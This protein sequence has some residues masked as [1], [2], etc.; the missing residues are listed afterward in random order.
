MKIYCFDPETGIYLGED[1]ADEGIRR[2]EYIIP[3]DATTIAPPPYKPGLEA[4]FFDPK[5]QRWELRELQHTRTRSLSDLGM[6]LLRE[7]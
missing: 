1:F 5:T 7:R 6:N 2:G 3:A 4:P